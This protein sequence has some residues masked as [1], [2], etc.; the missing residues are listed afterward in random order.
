MNEKDQLQG[1][2]GLFWS[3]ADHLLRTFLRDVHLRQ[4]GKSV[5]GTVEVPG[6]AWVRLLAES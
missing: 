5:G 1:A 4:D 2:S 3:R 6:H